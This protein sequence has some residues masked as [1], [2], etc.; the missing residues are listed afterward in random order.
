MTKRLNWTLVLILLAGTVVLGGGVHLLRAA[1]VRRNAP[2]L[3]EMAD[4]CER[5]R[6]LD[7]A[8]LFLRRYLERVPS[9][10]AARARY[11]L[12]RV[13]LARG[14]KELRNA[15]FS[16]EVL[17]RDHPGAEDVRR[18]AVRLAMSPALNLHAEARFHLEQLLK[19][20]RD[21]GELELLYAQC[22]L[23][24][25]HFPEA[26][27]WLARATEHAPKQIHGYVLRARVLREHLDQP[28]A[29]DG[30]MDAMVGAAG[31]AQARL[32]RAGYRGRHARDGAEGDAQR[33]LAEADVEEA[34]RL[35]PDDADVLLAYAQLSQ[36]RDES[37][38]AR[39]ALRRGLE[40][41]PRDMRLYDRL[42]QLEARAGRADEAIAC[43]SKGLDA[44]PGHPAL[45]WDLALLL[46]GTER[47]GEVSDLI[48]RLRKAG[49]AEARL[50][51]LDARLLVR[52]RRWLD[53]AQLL[54]RVH[55]LL[56]PWPDLSRQSDVFLA[57][58]F[59]QLGD[60]DRQYVAYQRAAKADP[61]WA[62]ACL[63]L[64]ESLERLG[65]PEEAVEVYRRILNRE[66]R[67]RLAVARL[68]IARN[69]ALPEK[70]QQW[71]PVEQLL[72]EAEAALPDG[73]H[74]AAVLRAEAALARGKA[75]EA[76]DV[77]RRA[78]DRQPE[79][80]DLWVALA[81]VGERAGKPETVLPLLDE[82]DRK[83]GDRVEI[84]LARAAYWARRGEAG[85]KALRDLEAGSDRLARED[86]LRLWRGLADA[87][88]RAGDTAGARQLWER[89]AAEE[90]NDLAA[91]IIL[92]DLALLGGDPERVARAV[93]EVRRIEG[94]EGTFWRYGRACELL[95][96]ARRG[97]TSRLDE[98]RR[99]LTEV[100]G[101]RPGW[102][103]VAVCE[104]E[105][106]A[107]AGDK[108]SA[109]AR[110]QKAVE[111]GER[112]PAL[113]GRLIGLLSEQRRYDEAGRALRLLPE[114]GPALGGLRRVAAEVSWH[115][116]DHD[117]ALA[118]AQKAV[119]DDGKDY[120]DHVW[121]AQMLWAARRHDEADAHF[122]RA[123]ELAPAAPAPWVARVQFLARTGKQ[124]RAA[125]LI[126]DARGKIA[127]DQ[128][129]LAL[130][131]CHEAV[132]QVKEAKELYD[133][134]LASRPQDVA[135]LRGL[136]LF[137][138]RLGELRE[139]EPLLQT[140]IRLTIR[141][142]EDAAWARRM[143]ALVLALQDDYQKSR[144]A[145][146][147]LGLLDKE[148]APSGADGVDE[149]RARALVLAVQRSRAKRLRAIRLIED[150]IGRQPPAP[151]DLFLLA[152]LY[153]SVGDGGR[154]RE[155]LH[156][157]VSAYPDNPLYLAR[158]ARALL[159]HKEVGEAANRVARLEK[160]QPGTF[161]AVELRARV[162]KEQGKGAEAVPLLSAHADR[163]PSS[164]GRVAALLEE[165]GHGRAAEDHYRRWAAASKQPGAGL[166]VAGCLAR[167]GRLGDALAACEEAGK[168]APPE[169]VAATA[170]AALYEAGP[171]AAQGARVRRL[172]EEGLRRSPGNLPLQ[173]SLA[174][175]CNLEG[176]YGEASELY[177]RVLARDPRD[178]LAMN[179]LAYL[180]ALREDKGAEALQLLRRAEQAVGELPDLLDT[181]AVVCLTLGRGEEA[182]AVLED[183]LVEVPSAGGYFHLAQA[184]RAARKPAE[185]TVALKKAL[186]MGLKPGDLHPLERP[187][188]QKLRADLGV[189]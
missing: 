121:L 140:I 9:D 20:R 42:A 16:L 157:L 144:R 177:R 133:K 77:L 34:R 99:L 32:A 183:L 11:A 89:L 56:E 97:D 50:D 105:I 112:G 184:Y 181:R 125:A 68:L 139:A 25:K 90:P 26:E 59:A 75:D 166:V 175:L 159:R 182:V 106:A 163:E 40:L 120:R 45:L 134:A 63:G 62:P 98:A 167:Q 92:F 17:L 76:Q 135:V 61:L 142:P 153:E 14:P 164:L 74:E 129:A 189:N 110:F 160:L 170:V 43:L 5:E 57:R 41:H 162:L 188:L 47:A 124:D 19:A 73:G 131:Q 146:E 3:L 44:L 115:T 48:G 123:V 156:R 148:D 180:L 49:V 52:K 67:A 101:R 171:S 138:L 82:A 18:E 12:L 96:R 23:A 24:E 21:D 145:L 186:G 31:S 174:A 176:R 137:Q 10:M 102:S 151:E 39:T 114:Q 86:R 38:E 28:G 85:R 65:R 36:V 88:A 51:Y 66:P 130:A 109:I 72:R 79:Q 119:A 185:A 155:W 64:G 6:K 187:A 104:G 136:V 1:Q 127:P 111:Q 169:A 173:A 107:L 54:E 116:G 70:E 29:A 103:R 30:G 84:R 152:Q 143:L 100:S 58:C 4:R 91:H 172:I 13:R 33:K 80:V 126:E 15:F 168:T 8:H 22:L 46:L 55:P 117:R 69:G 2:V 83:L 37:E 60:A 93:G 178:A 165:L 132:G 122:R 128:A 81:A 141:A 53:A 78:R 154:A 108:S 161:Q 149:L 179:N 147:V 7:D 35:A 27:Q 150:A 113:L 95:V 87:H 118:L 94:P 158:Y 71:P